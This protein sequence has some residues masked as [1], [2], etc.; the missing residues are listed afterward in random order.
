MVMES[1]AI[2]QIPKYSSS[3]RN[4]LL[5][6]IFLGLSLR[7]LFF[8][9][10]LG[11]EHWAN[12]AALYSRNDHAEFEKWFAILSW[13]WGIHEYFKENEFFFNSLYYLAFCYV[14]RVLVLPAFKPT[15][16]L[17]E[18]FPLVLFR[19]AVGVYLLFPACEIAYSFWGG[20]GYY[21][22]LW[23]AITFFILCLVYLLLEGLAL[24]IWGRWFRPRKKG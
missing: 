16:A 14:V 22:D 9:A 24:W 12:H 7:F 1:P 4:V 10:E 8:F 13:Q 15:A 2:D 6:L 21:A 18:A 23:W 11:L 17:L 20:L 19:L 3:V 5:Y